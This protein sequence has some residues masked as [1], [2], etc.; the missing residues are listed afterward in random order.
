MRKIV[1]L[2]A[3]F[4]LILSSC[5]EK[6]SGPEE[7][8]A[9][10]SFSVNEADFVTLKGAPGTPGDFPECSDAPL[11]FAVIGIVGEAEDKIVEIF[12]ANN[13]YVTQPFKIL[14]GQDE[15]TDITIN[16]F[17]VYDAHPDNGGV[18]VRAAPEFE[19]DYWYF[20]SPERRLDL[21]VT[22]E[23]F[24]KI[25]AAID[26][27]CFEDLFYENF[28]FTWFK[29]DL[30]TVK[31]LCFFGDICTGKLEQYIFDNSPY[32]GQAGNYDLAAI[33]QVSVYK[34][35]LT[36]GETEFS[37]VRT[38]TNADWNTPGVGDCMQVYW[39]DY[40][41][42]DEDYKLVLEVLLPIGDE[43]TYVEQQT[44]M[45]NDDAIGTTDPTYPQTNMFD[46]DTDDGVVDFVIGNC[47]YD[48]PDYTF[49][50]HQNIPQ[51][52]LTMIVR[53]GFD[54]YYV[55]LE[56]TGASSTGYDFLTNGTKL[57]GWCGD[58]FE[59]I[60]L[61][62][63]Y[64]VKA[65][66]SLNI[67]P[68]LLSETHLDL[69]KIQKLNYL[70]NHIK[71]V[72]G[73]FDYSAPGTYGNV[74]KNAIWSITDG[75]GVSGDAQSLRDNATSL[76]SGYIPKPG[77]WAAIFFYDGQEANRVQIMFTVVDP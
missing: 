30:M 65:Y 39:G 10:V 57:G 64:T 16:K 41:E 69:L 19:S 48:D 14:M 49:L 18:V 61:N 20:A 35:N 7:Q 26:V 70:F 12:F 31:S 1:M 37:L 62:T 73:D 45:F 55:G 44:W 43:L 52:D 17:L 24:K 74:I 60:W 66:S 9:E 59:N 36:D 29:L 76:G 46:A 50:P 23:K 28:G 54:G 72:I 22:V 3:A 58:K 53:G 51:G 68:D 33:M 71:D 21:V 38:Y 34:K 15:T 5:N 27:L 8:F 67:D 6:V 11:K 47:S 32:F 13:K 75:V 4:A 63:P 2:M 42:K 56:F 40:D 25:E 77:E